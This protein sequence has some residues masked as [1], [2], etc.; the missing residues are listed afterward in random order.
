MR[1]H[2]DGVPPS[3]SRFGR[4]SGQVALVFLLL[5]AVLA[6]LVAMNADVF[7]SVTRKNQLENAGDAAALAAARSQ[8][9]ILNEIGRLNLERVEAMLEGDPERAASALERQDEL[10]LSGPVEGALV[11]AQDA[12]KENRVYVDP[13]MTKLLESR[14]AAIRSYFD[15]LDDEKRLRA[16]VYASAL[17]RAIF[18]TGG[19]AAGPDNMDLFDFN[20]ESHML[21]SKEFY[22]AILG[23]NWCWFHFNA[24]DLLESYR[25][26]SDW[27]PLPDSDGMDAVANSEVFSLG[28]VMRNADIVAAVGAD[29]LAHQ[30]HE[31]GLAMHWTGPMLATNETLRSEEN[32][33]CFY[34]SRM[35]RG[36]EEACRLSEFMVGNV[37]GEYDV[38]GCAAVTRVIA[39]VEPSMPGESAKTVVWTAAAKPFGCVRMADGGLLP[40]TALGGFVLPSFTAAR[41]IPVDAAFAGGFD[42]ADAPW[43]EHIFLHLP[44]YLERGR[45][46]RDCRWCEALRTWESDGFREGGRLWL[47]LYSHTCVRPLYGGDERS[48]GRRHGH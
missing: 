2:L 24:P 46:L 4:R 5:I 42:T 38:L 41:L 14:S 40:C 13:G 19:I 33:W 32:L 30:L 18:S 35:W 39:A 12:A 15:A 11:A 23:R 21:Y 20:P 10:R 29:E 16:D 28:V 8:G 48:G 26:H 37:K 45:A 22:D 47:A 44:G 27:A 34:D 31:C 43:M 25:N 36:W 7:F 1:R 17:E 3:I 9:L 6:C